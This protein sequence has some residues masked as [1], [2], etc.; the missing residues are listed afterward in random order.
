MRPRL[1]ELLE[2]LQAIP[3]DPSAWEDHDIEKKFE[4]TC[5]FLQRGILEVIEQ[6]DEVN[7]I[8]MGLQ[9]S[10]R[11]GELRNQLAS[12]RDSQLEMQAELRKVPYNTWVQ[13]GFRLPSSQDA[14]TSETSRSFDPEQVSDVK[15]SPSAQCIGQS[16]RSNSRSNTPNELI[17]GMGARSKQQQSLKRPDM[18]DFGFRPY[19]GGEE[20]VESWSLF[21]VSK[22]EVST[23]SIH[24]RG[25][26]SDASTNDPKVARYHRIAADCGFH[27]Y[28]S[29][30]QHH[31][32]ADGQRSASTPDLLM[33]KNK[34]CPS[35]PQLVKTSS[36]KGCTKQLT[37]TQGHRGNHLRKLRL[38]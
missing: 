5:S 32:M 3:T 33:E 16:R 17:L 4:D 37:G 30:L 6:S 9:H 34:R 7:C 18:F 10:V 27:E 21:K 31:G 29:K 35:L 20:S 38:A 24:S 11:F 15:R 14:H 25:I 19:G 36:Q 23:D 22:S 28:V 12:V 8:Y 26:R 13:S 1:V 2:Q